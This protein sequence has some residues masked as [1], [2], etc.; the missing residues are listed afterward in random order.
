MPSRTEFISTLVDACRG[1]S[2]VAG[3]I[4]YGSGGQGRLDQWSDVDVV[5]FVKNW[6][7]DD[8]HNGWKTWAGRLGPL[9]HAYRG[10]YGFWAIYPDSPLP[11][12]VDCDLRRESDI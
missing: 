3:L 1:D 8:F 9:I 7:F 6:H 5:V 11:L 2:R 12:R 4:D 10:R